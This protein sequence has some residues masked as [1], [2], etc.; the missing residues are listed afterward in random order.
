MTDIILVKITGEDFEINI[1]ADR[2]Y[3]C[4]KEEYAKIFNGRRPH[5]SVQD[6]LLCYHLSGSFEY[7]TAFKKYL[8]DVDFKDTLTDKIYRINKYFTDSR[9]GDYMAIILQKFPLQSPVVRYNDDDNYYRVIDCALKEQVAHQ[10]V[11]DHEEYINRIVA[12]HNK[13]NKN[14]FDKA[15]R[16]NYNG[17]DIP[18]YILPLVKATVI[19][20]NVS[21]FDFKFPVKTLITTCGGKALSIENL[22]IKTQE[23]IKCDDIKNVFV[24]FLYN[25][26]LKCESFYTTIKEEEFS[27][28]EFDTYMC[29]HEYILRKLVNRAKKVIIYVD[30][31][32]QDIEFDF[33]HYEIRNKLRKPQWYFLTTFA[34]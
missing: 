3:L 16:Y 22:K 32:N 19:I 15:Y 26:P 2:Q 10:Y 21:N 30:G 23:R 33:P 28:I 1:K 14:Q 8:D 4:K 6:G 11:Q 31:P 29:D 12:Y 9:E 17:D 7:V 34:Y 18:D 5:D 24:E 25:H 20:T 27:N 13:T